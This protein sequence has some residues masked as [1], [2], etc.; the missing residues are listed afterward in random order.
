[1]IA[2]G[3]LVAS[4]THDLRQPLT[5]LEMN[6]SAAVRLLERGRASGEG[7]PAD[8]DIALGALRDAIDDLHEMRE[9]LQAVQDLAVRRDPFL[10]P[11]DLAESLRDAAHLV[12][13]ETAGGQL[14]VGLTAENPTALVFADKALVKQAMLNILL[15]AMDSIAPDANDTRNVAADVRSHDDN[16]VD[17]TI[18]YH[19]DP[20]SRQP[21]QWN[22][23]LARS[24]AEVHGATLHSEIDDDSYLT[25]LTRWPIHRVSDAGQTS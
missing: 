14:T 19:R 4:I 24:V 18:R 23:A 12:S 15:D 21:D 10:R 2:A 20:R 11:I 3:E 6:V 9:A 1:L 7:N 5:A 17:V 25:V 8:S 16:F 13:T 22:L